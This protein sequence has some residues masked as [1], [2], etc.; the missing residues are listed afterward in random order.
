MSKRFYL[1]SLKLRLQQ[2]FENGLFSGQ[3]MPNNL[4]EHL[5]NKRLPWEQNQRYLVHFI[6]FEDFK[7]TPNRL[8]NFKSLEIKVFKSQGGWLYPPPPPPVW[9]G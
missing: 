4:Q 7:S 2:E 9:E 3:I 6:F 8:L 1:L 5:N